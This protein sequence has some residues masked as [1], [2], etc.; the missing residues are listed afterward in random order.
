[1]DKS[2]TAIATDF[3]VQVN[4]RSAEVDDDLSFPPLKRRL[5]RFESDS[6]EEFRPHGT[7]TPIEEEEKK[8]AKEEEEKK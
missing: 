1:M 3:L 2:E 4:K 7:S 5:I 8:K 6:E